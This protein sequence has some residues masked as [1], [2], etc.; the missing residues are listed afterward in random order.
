[1]FLTL[2][3]RSF[4]SEGIGSSSF[5]YMPRMADSVSCGGAVLPRWDDAA[6]D[7]L[8]AEISA[9]TPHMLELRHLGGALYLFL[10][11]MLGPDQPQFSVFS[12]RPPSG[13]VV[14][15]GDLLAGGDR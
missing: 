15:L 4:S 8:L 9:T 2:S 11:G 12:W 14:A 7:V 13:L 6:I 5:L 10:R 3:S 1:M